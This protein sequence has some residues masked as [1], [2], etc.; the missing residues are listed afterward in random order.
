MTSVAAD[1]RRRFI[2]DW[3]RR[4][5][6]VSRTQWWNRPTLAPH[7]VLSA[8]EGVRKRAASFLGCE[9]NELTGIASSTAP[10]RLFL[11]AQTYRGTHRRQV[12]APIAVTSG[13]V[14]GPRSQMVRSFISEMA[15]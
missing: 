12:T 6:G 14:H 1:S 4:R 9:Q 5:S 7:L 15:L 11:S 3:A 10:V 8:A 2:Q 13:S